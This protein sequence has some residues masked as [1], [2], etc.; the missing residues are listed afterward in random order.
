MDVWMDKLGLNPPSEGGDP[1]RQFL[2]DLGIEL[3]PVIARLY[4]KAMNERVYQPV[5]VPVAHPKYE[6]LIGTP[7]RL[8]TGQTLGVELKS[9][10]DYSDEF[11]EP[12]TDQVPYHYLIQC[13]HYMAI[14]EYSH[15]DVALLKS[16]S[17][18]SIYHLHR[19]LDLENE[20]IDQLR[21]WWDYHIIKKIP[22]DLDGSDAWK[23]YIKQKFPMET[24]PV[25]K[26]TEART[27]M[28]VS[29]LRTI[30]GAAEDL[31]FQQTKVEN[32]L[33][34]IIG[35]HSGL[36][37]EF[38]RITWKKTKDSNHVDWQAAFHDLAQKTND[39][40][41]AADSIKAQTTTKPGTRRFLLNTRKDWIFNGTGIE[42]GSIGTNQISGNAGNRIHSV[43]GPGKS[44]N[45]GSIR[46]GGKT[47]S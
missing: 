22:P 35:E 13:A 14:M 20:M 24:L 25:V 5:V 47:S 45:R 33:K 3:E 30:R 4:E 42:A 44:L 21:E 17:A 11:G 46:D 37:G 12:G 8:V 29:S 2:M 38:G 36:I 16:G 31:E 34:E 9:E 43:S 1:H 23:R 32:A 26:T 28:L 18:F 19:D 7:D 39:A 6:F 40:G 10:S 27:L 41:W 15:W